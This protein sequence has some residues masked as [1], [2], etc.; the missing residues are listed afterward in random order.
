M[1]KIST[2][3]L[4]SDFSFNL[5]THW[6]MGTFVLMNSFKLSQKFRSNCQIFLSWA[7]ISN[8]NASILFEINIP[9]KKPLR[10]CSFPKSAAQDSRELLHLCQKLVYTCPLPAAICIIPVCKEWVS[11]VNNQNWILPIYIISKITRCKKLKNSGQ[12]ASPRSAQV[13]HI[14]LLYK[15]ILLYTPP[16][17]YTPI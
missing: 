15:H 4:W 10:F 14:K 3:S 13:N 7:T 2:G 16:L 6:S 8:N 5:P 17:I 11:L 12:K 9:E 1:L